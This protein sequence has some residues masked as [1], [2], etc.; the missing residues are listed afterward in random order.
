MLLLLQLLCSRSGHY[1]GCLAYLGG[2]QYFKLPLLLFTCL[3]VS[4]KLLRFLLPPLLIL[5]HVL[6]LLFGYLLSVC[7][8]LCISTLF[9]SCSEAL[10]LTVLI[11]DRAF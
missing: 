7:M 8:S 2:A 9:P 10:L 1:I 3:L 11:R 4:R 6:L 5:C